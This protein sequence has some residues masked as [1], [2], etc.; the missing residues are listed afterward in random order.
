MGG[1]DYKHTNSIFF[2]LI[3]NESS[4]DSAHSGSEPVDKNAPSDAPFYHLRSIKK[5]SQSPPPVL[6]SRSSPTL[7]TTPLRLPPLD[8]PDDEEATPSPNHENPKAARQALCNEMSE[9]NP[10]PSLTPNSSSSSLTFTETLKLLKL[11]GQSFLAGT[12]GDHLFTSLIASFFAELITL[13]LETLKVL[14]QVHGGALQD[15]AMDTFSRAGLSGFFRGGGPRLFQTVA[16]NVGFFFWHTLFKQAGLGNILQGVVSRIKE[17]NPKG[18]RFALNFFR[19]AEKTLSIT[20]TEEDISSSTPNRSPFRGPT[21]FDTP[22]P[23]WLSMAMNMMAQMVNRVFCSP[24]EVVANVVQASTSAEGKSTLSVIQSVYKRDGWGG[25]WKGLGVSLVLSLNPALMFTLVEKMCAFLRRGYGEKEISSSQMFRI[26]AGAKTI[27]T[28]LTYPLIR[29]KVVMQMSSL[30]QQKGLLA[31]LFWG[32]ESNLSDLLL[33][34]N[35][36]PEFGQVLIT[37]KS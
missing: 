34:R 3:G 18:S 21:S 5:G 36:Y 35:N 28:L 1:I 19:P 22:P 30:K 33:S 9:M 26:S 10:N 4:Y 11:R 17:V 8:I 14:Q 13:P 27:A 6:G 29:A 24:L 16:S 31:T 7:E 25:F 20:K 15:V 37:L 23:I 32:K 12:M 2:K